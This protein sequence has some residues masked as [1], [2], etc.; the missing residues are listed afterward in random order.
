VFAPPADRELCERLHAIH[1][2]VASLIARLRPE[3][4]AVEDVFHSR[5]THSALVLGQVRGVVLLA[6][7][8]AGLPVHALA[9][10]TVKVQITGFGGADKS[11]VAF[12]VARLLSLPGD[13]E[14]GD[15]ADA[16]AVALCLAHRQPLAAGALLPRASR[17][18]SAR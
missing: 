15:A 5:N 6:G 8:Q 14:A 13:G 17:R 1:A 9:P 3:A 10:A 11:Q 16:L 18:R 7:A 12:M 4:L 2:G